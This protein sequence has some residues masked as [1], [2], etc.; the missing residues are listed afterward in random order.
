MRAKMAFYIHA[1]DAVGCITLRRNTHDAAA[2]KAEELKQ[3]GYFDVD[4][5]D[6]S[7]NETADLPAQERLVH[8]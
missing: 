3:M 6:R 2:K 5:V 4:I 8:Q 7:K 1:R